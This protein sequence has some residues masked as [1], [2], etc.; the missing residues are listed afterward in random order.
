[1]IGIT[2]RPPVSFAVTITLVDF[3]EPIGPAAADGD[4]LNCNQITET[5]LAVSASPTIEIGALLG[6]AAA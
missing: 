6:V 1:M 3:D 2:I 5:E 4:T